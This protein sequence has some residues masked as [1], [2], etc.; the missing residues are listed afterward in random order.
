MTPRPFTDGSSDGSSVLVIV[1]PVSAAGTLIVI[2]MS[3][4]Y[5][6]CFAKKDM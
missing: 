3:V 5:T 1:V 4:V 2:T 6:H